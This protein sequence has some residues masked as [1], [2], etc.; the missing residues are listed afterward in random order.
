M[1]DGTSR[2]RSARARSTKKTPSGNVI[3]QLGGGLQRQPR[4]AGPAGT[5][6]RQQLHVRAPQEAATAPTSCSRPR[7]GVGWR[8]VV[9]PGVRA[10]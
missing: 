4:L 7:K 3:Q 5:G 6:Q 9:R 1:A 10:T 2:D 8:E